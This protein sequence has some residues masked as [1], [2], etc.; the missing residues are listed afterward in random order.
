M[1]GHPNVRP[2]IPVGPDVQCYTHLL[3]IP[4]V[5]YDR[6]LH[7]GFLLRNKLVAEGL[8]TWHVEAWIE[9]LGEQSEGATLHH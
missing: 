2:H 4:Q 8:S 5:G 7:V 1:T 6:A 3:S 9:L